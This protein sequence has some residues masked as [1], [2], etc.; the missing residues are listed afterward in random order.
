MCIGESANPFRDRS[1]TMKRL[2]SQ[3]LRERGVL[4]SE[5]AGV[6]QTFTSLTDGCS[7][8]IVDERH[9]RLLIHSLLQ[10]GNVGFGHDMRAIDHLFEELVLSHQKL[11]G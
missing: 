4:C 7:K 5:D 9:D 6:V 3:V 2:S 8:A 1:V 11:T 10:S